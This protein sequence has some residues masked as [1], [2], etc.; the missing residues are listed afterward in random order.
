MSPTQICVT[1][2]ELRHA[3]TPEQRTTYERALIALA[4]LVGETVTAIDGKAKREMT[5]WMLHLLADLW[6]AT[7]PLRKETT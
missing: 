5:A 7:I 3:T 2:E 6:S 4:D 1:V